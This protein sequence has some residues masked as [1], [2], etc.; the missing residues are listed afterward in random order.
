MTTLR[1]SALTTYLLLIGFSFFWPALA[2]SQV[3]V[4]II[5]QH[6]TDLTGTLSP[7]QAANLET[8]LTAL[9]ARKGS[10]FMIVM[11]PTIQPQD[12]ESFSLATFEKNKIG[13]EKEDD[14]LLL[15]IAKDDRKARIEVGRGLEGAIPDV[16]AARIIREYLAPKF[17]EN[18][19]AGGLNDASAVIEKIIDGEPLPEP[20]AEPMGDNNKTSG[21]WFIAFW[22]GIFVGLFATGVPVKPI[23]IRRILAGSGAGFLAFTFFSLGLPAVAAAVIAFLISG[24]KSNGRYVSHGGGGFGGRWGG[25]GGWS[26]GSSGSSG[27]GWSGGGGSSAGGGASGSW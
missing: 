8:K 22:I 19:Y 25:G 18:D 12:I 2:I 21:S 24:A 14:G 9:E 10:Q 20:M 16:A 13:R 6:V 1:V 26:G 3:Q 5:R 15:L 11:L 27:G 17:R 23:F 4:P 7:A